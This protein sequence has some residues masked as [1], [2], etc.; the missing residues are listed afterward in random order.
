MHGR[1]LLFAFAHLSLLCGCTEVCTPIV[2]ER[3]AGEA[4]LAQAFDAAAT[5]TIRGR[6]TWEGAVPIAEET[7][8]R[9]IA[10]NPHLH[11]NPAR[12]VTPHIPKVHAANRGIYNAVVFLRAVD[13]GRSKAWDHAKVC[14]EFRDRQLLVQQGSQNVGVGFVRRGSV[15][16]VVNRDSEYHNLQAR[17]A[18]FFA[19]PLIGVNQVHERKLSQ[20][21]KVDLTCG[22]GYYWLHAH[23]FVVEHPYYARTDAD[24]RFTLEQVPAGS[25]EIVFWMPNWK[26]TR[27]EA[28]PETGIIARLAWG[29]PKEQKLHVRV[30]VGRTSQMSW[31]WSP[32][33]FDK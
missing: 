2:Q 17:G 26:V 18:A 8:V 22:A 24:G 5:G 33:M 19:L 12:F 29:E 31:A 4:T 1:I 21:G 15:I 30:E 32:A 16:E 13:P 27:K 25:Y 3:E 11:Q 6:V 20:A 23:L 7:V 10:F 14:V 9:A 28:D